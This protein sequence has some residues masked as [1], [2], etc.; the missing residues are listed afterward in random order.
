MCKKIF[1]IFLFF[2]ILLNYKIYSEEIFAYTIRTIDG[3]V[4]LRGGSESIL[5]AKEFLE[6]NIDKS[7]STSSLAEILGKENIDGILEIEKYS[8]IKEGREEIIK[9]K[10]FYS[11]TIKEAEEKGVIPYIEG[12]SFFEAK[13]YL[14]MLG[15]TVLHPEIKIGKTNVSLPVDITVQSAGIYGGNFAK[16]VVDGEDYSPDKRGYNIAV[17]DPT[18]GEVEKVENFD[19]RSDER[20]KFFAQKMAEFLEDIPDGKIVVCAVKDEGSKY[21]SATCV[22]ALKRIGANLDLRGFK[23]FSHAII[24]VKGAKPGEALEKRD[25]KMVEL[26]VLKGI[27]NVEEELEELAEKGAQAIFLPIEFKEDS[28]IKLTK[29]FYYAKGNK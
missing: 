19:T 12:L 23:R 24:G 10:S 5:K 7:L 29:I 16:I 27:G 15:F 13:A 18:T 14:E 20:G 2:L 21:L 4:L 26:M 22:Q 3:A 8:P 25:S 17:I 11:L 9:E 6:K 1:I 28:I